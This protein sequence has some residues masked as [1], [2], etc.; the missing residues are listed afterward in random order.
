MRLINYIKDFKYKSRWKYVLFKSIFSVLV[1]I[2]NTF[3][4]F[5]RSLFSSLK[6][7]QSIE[8]K[9]ISRAYQDSYFDKLNES[10]KIVFCGDMLLLEDQVKRGYNNG[11]YDYNDVFEHTKDI[12]KSADLSIGVLEGP[13][14]RTSSFS[15]SNYGDGKLLSINF[16]AAF[17]NALKESGFDLVTLANNHILD[18]GSHG[19]LETIDLLNR[20]G[21]N[22][23]VYQS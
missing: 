22:Y 1:R 18:K 12:L 15:T 21:L 16:P 8:E 2:K 10:F 6:A 23:A 7:E 4:Q 13:S 20:I 5:F 11:K 9:G 17:P 14:D 19:L 3:K